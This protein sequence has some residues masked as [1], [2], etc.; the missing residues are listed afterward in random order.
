MGRVVIGTMHTILTPVGWHHNI[1][2]TIPRAHLHLLVVDSLTCSSPWLTLRPSLRRLCTSFAMVLQIRTPTQRGS[3][4]TTSIISKRRKATSQEV[5]YDY[6]WL[7]R[8]ST[9]IT[10]VSQVSYIEKHE[11]LGL[12]LIEGGVP[13][14]DLILITWSEDFLTTVWAMHVPLSL[15]P[16]FIQFEARSKW[17]AWNSVKGESKESAMQNYI[18]IVAADFENWETHPVLADY[19][20]E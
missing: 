5:R 14:S 11:K 6:C 12:R 19:T 15:Q 16:L 18:D 7:Y 20:P 1:S 2:P 17:D 13:L 9:M 10:C 8:T 4:P 3:W